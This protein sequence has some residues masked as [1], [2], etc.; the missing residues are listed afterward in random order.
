MAH[1]LKYVPVC[2]SKVQ[3]LVGWCQYVAV[4][5]QIIQNEPLIITT[6]SKYMY[7]ERNPRKPF[8]RMIQNIRQHN[9]TEKLRGI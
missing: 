1:S 7:V 6:K 4:R 3:G 2:I 9:A 8:P 5:I